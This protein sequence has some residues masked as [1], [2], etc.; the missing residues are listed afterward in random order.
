MIV[1]AGLVV[2]AMIVIVAAC[3]GIAAGLAWAIGEITTRRQDRR[4]RGPDFRERKR[5]GPGRSE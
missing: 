4:Q 1:T 2:I 3:A 5:E